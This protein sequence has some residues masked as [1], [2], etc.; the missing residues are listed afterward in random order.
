MQTQHLE[1]FTLLQQALSEGPFYAVP[2]AQSAPE[3]GAGNSP[4]LQGVLGMMLKQAEKLWLW[5]KADCTV[6]CLGG[7]TIQR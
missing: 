6:D 5:Y 1:Q 3:L 7:G 2:E 4:F